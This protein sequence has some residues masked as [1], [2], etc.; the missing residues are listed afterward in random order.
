[1]SNLKDLVYG[2]AWGDALGHPFEFKSPTPQEIRDRLKDDSIFQYTDDTKLLLSTVYAL[3]R[4]SLRYGQPRDSKFWEAMRRDAN[5]W[6]LKWYRSGDLRGIGVTTH[7]ALNQMNL[8]AQN[9]GDLAKFKLDRKNYPYDLS[10]GN[11]ILSRAIPLLAVGFEVDEKLIQFLSVT[12]LHPDGVEAVRCLAGYLA[13]RR[14]KESK[15]WSTGQGFYAP[16]TVKIAAHAVDSGVEYAKV[17]AASQVPEGDNDSTAALAL[18]IS[19][20][21]RGIGR[22]SDHLMRRLDKRDHMEIE[23]ALDP[24]I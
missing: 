4:N 17:F 2:F 5:D 8:F 1:M 11:G 21:N 9:E 18:G 7:A 15:L 22:S 16:E 6:L 13:T 10:A 20:F 19:F 12:H 24:G 3:S 23:S 14:L